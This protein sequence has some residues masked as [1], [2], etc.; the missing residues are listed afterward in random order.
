M[1]VVPAAGAHPGRAATAFED[2]LRRCERCQIGASNATDADAVT[3]IHFDPLQ[4]VPIEVRQGAAA[5]LDVALNVRNRE[6]KRRR[7]GFSTSEDAVTWVV[8]VHLLRSGQLA[9]VLSKTGVIEVEVTSPPAL[10]LW[11]SPID[12]DIRASELRDRL[13][14]ESKALKEDPQSSSEPDVIV[15]LGQAGLV[16]IEVKYRSGNDLKKASDYPGWDRYFDR[17]GIFSSEA[18]VRHSGC[19]EL[20]RNW[21]LVHG[22]A[23]GRPAVLVNLGPARLFAGSEGRRLDGF[24]NRLVRSKGSRFIRLSWLELLDALYESPAW[25][26]K[27]CLSRNLF[28]N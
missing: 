10:L 23:G 5:A 9:K 18:A 2:C 13:I 3:H 1:S 15:D 7:F 24:V 27:Y 11:G 4:N 26:M 14:A 25:F 6:T 22:L 28:G 17:P 16:F 8:F 19:Y 12:G 20:A 21:R